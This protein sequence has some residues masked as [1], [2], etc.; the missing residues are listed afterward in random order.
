LNYEVEIFCTTCGTDIVEDSDGDLGCSC[1]DE[2]GIYCFAPSWVGRPESIDLVA[3]GDGRRNNFLL[4]RGS[5]RLL[6]IEP[7]FALTGFNLED[8]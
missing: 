2:D 6:V 5:N 4:T 1:P 8:E 7:G 3:V